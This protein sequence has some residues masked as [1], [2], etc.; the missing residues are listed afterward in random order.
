MRE[1]LLSKNPATNELVGEVEITQIEDIKS[2]VEKSKIAQKQ[3]AKLTIDERVVYLQKAGDILNLRTKELAV[4]LAKEMGKDLGRATGEV[5]GCANDIT[6]N[7]REIKKAITTQ[8]IINYGVKT[9]LKYNPL[10]VCAVIAPWNYP[11]AMGHWVMIPALI[12]GNSVV[13]KP[14]EETPLIAKAYVEIF[15]S[16]L[17]KDVLQVVYGDEEQ[18]KA[19]VNADVN[20]IAFT[21]SKEAG[22][23]IMQNAANGLKRLILEL[24]GKDPLLVLDDANISAAA[25]FAVASSF[26]NAGQM[27][28]ST[29]RVYVAKEVLKEFEEKVVEYARGYK[30]GQWDDPEANIGPIINKKQRDSILKQIEDAKDKGAKVLLG[31]E[32]HPD[33]FITPTVLTNITD[34]MLIFKNETF[35]PIVAITSFEDVNEAIKRA[36]SS[37]FA[38]GASIFGY[39]DVDILSQELDAGM[40]GINQGSGSIGDTP[41]VGAKKSGYGYHGSPDGH[42]QFTQPKVISRSHK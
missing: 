2:I 39:K 6:F 42:R 5:S 41:W 22:E 20:L 37:D 14:S 15:Q 3:W 17:P 7:A 29:E 31:G 10:G 4:L 25:R 1:K 21:G 12:A 24:G 40:L 13:Y 8:T 23:N 11:L 19:L 26:E 28:T 34:D 35:G 9:E 32:N 36:N 33:G 27:C 30:L 18:G 38:L 16:V